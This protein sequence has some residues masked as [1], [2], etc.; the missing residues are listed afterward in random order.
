VV[1]CR[2]EES[3]PFGVLKIRQQDVGQLEGLLEPTFVE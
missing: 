3:R 2:V 1:V